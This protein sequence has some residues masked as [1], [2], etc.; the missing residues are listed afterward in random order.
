MMMTMMKKLVIRLI[1]KF[2]MF[3][4]QTIKIKHDLIRDEIIERI[5]GNID[6]S[7]FSPDQ[8]QGSLE[9]N[10]SIDISDMLDDTEILLSKWESTYIKIWTKHRLENCWKTDLHIIESQIW[11]YL[12]EDDIIRYEDDFGRN[13]NVIFN[14]IGR[15]TTNKIYK[16]IF[17]TD[18]PRHSTV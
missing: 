6:E 11:D 9:G 13:W 7:M 18:Y 17:Y 16:T 1:D 10:T 4:L 12:E 14:F 2:M 15:N 8:W 5:D 3:S